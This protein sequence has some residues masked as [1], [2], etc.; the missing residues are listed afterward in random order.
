LES[1]CGRSLDYGI[2]RGQFA[3][4]T[5]LAE[6]CQRIVTRLQQERPVQELE[7]LTAISDE[8]D[9]ETIAKAVEKQ[10]RRMNLN[11]ALT[12]CIHSSSSTYVHFARNEV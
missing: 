3:E 11:R 6:A 9:F 8:R 5:G 10:L 2:D 7:A 4:K 12:A 1:C